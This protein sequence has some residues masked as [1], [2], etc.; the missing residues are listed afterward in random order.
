L[1]TN[2]PNDAAGPRHRKPGPAQLEGEDVAGKRARDL[3]YTDDEHADAEE[4]QQSWP[5]PNAS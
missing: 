3:T 1:R 2:H 5:T 4:D